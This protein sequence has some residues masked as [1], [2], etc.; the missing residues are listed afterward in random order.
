MGL[1]F[2][3]AAAFLAAALVPLSW[4]TIGEITRTSTASGTLIWSRI[5]IRSGA[6]S[7]GHSIQ[8]AP[9]SIAARLSETMPQAAPTT[10]WASRLDLDRGQNMLHPSIR[11][12]RIFPGFASGPGGRRL[13]IPT[14][15]LAAPLAACTWLLA[16]RHRRLSRLENHQC[17][18]CGYT[19]TGIAPTAPCPECGRPQTH[20][21]SSPPAPTSA[22]NAVG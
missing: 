21:T 9:W 6:I 7:L 5:Q 2:C 11:P 8:S 15:N 20:S 14:W 12:G 10:S 1:I 17:P 16:R 22:A 19:L 13:T 3:S 18:T 4:M